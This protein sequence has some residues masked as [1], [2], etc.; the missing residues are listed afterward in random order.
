[1]ARRVIEPPLEAPKLFLRADVQEDFDDVGA[2]GHQ[3]LLESVDHRVTLSPDLLGNELMHAGHQHILVMRAVENDDLALLR[4]LLFDAPQEVMRGFLLR[5]DF[6]AVDPRPLGVHRTEDV[7]DG[8]ILS[9]GI[10]R[11]QTDEQRAFA[12]SIKQILQLAQ[13]HVESL[14]LLH[15]RLLLRMVSREARVDLLQAD[16]AAWSDLE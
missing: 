9:G 15:R 1:M 8:A 10:Q 14:D 12:L 2:T 16:F 11:L 7:I 13:L 5:R 3:F 6:E 4:H